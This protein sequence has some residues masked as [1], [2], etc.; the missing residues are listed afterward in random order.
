[1]AHV[2]RWVNPVAAAVCLGFLGLLMAA[3]VMR[4]EYYPFTGYQMFSRS[5]GPPVHYFRA[6]DVTAEGSLRPTRMAEVLPI[7]KNS[8]YRFSL[9][10]LLK[11]PGKRA[12]A[13]E[14]VARYVRMANRAG[15]EPIV[16]VEVQWWRWDFEAAPDDRDHGEMVRKTVVRPTL[17]TASEWAG[18]E[19]R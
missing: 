6:Y 14:L 10:R 7:L 11:E 2:R 9:Q 4:T 18:E 19:T 1:M 13:E 5:K 3:G 17:S 16:G 12:A 15:G 8:R